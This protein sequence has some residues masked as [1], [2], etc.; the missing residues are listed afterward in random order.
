MVSASDKCHMSHGELDI[1]VEYE[2]L[3]KGVGTL[4][5][6]DKYT[7][8]LKV[9]LYSLPAH[10]LP[11]TVIPNVKQELD[12]MVAARI[13]RPIDELTPFCSLMVVVYKK[14]GD[15]H[16]VTNFCYLNKNIRREEFQI[17]TIEELA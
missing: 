15:I 9:Q 14:T 17:P 12:R 11:P 5:M 4:C 6:G 8:T 2:S 10:R 1:F 7:V 16:I 3:F 13:I